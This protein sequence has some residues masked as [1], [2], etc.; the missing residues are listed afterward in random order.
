MRAF[1]K[2]KEREVLSR[3]MYKRKKRLVKKD[4]HSKKRLLLL[5]I[6]GGLI[7]VGAV[8]YNGASAAN[9]Q[10]QKEEQAKIQILEQLFE[11]A[12][13]K[14]SNEQLADALAK[15]EA[16]SKKALEL[17][18]QK[19]AQLQQRNQT[20]DTPQAVAQEIVVDDPVIEAS[21]SVPE[22]SQGNVGMTF[23]GSLNSTAYT[24]TGGNMANGEYPYFGAVACN[25]VPLGTTIYIEGLGNFV[26]KDRIGHGSD[27]DIFM[28]TYDECMA[29]G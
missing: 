3:S 16:E 10:Y 29:Y 22:K 23:L 14:E 4:K 7:M 6:A 21:P 8:S 17:E 24:H 26:V 27:L 11:E 12:K 2:F 9:Q 28:N 13:N 18:A 20:V 19:N 25:L 1:I 5:T 15:A